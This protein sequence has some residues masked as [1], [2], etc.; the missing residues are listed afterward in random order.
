MT[1]PQIPGYTTGTWTI[2]QAHSDVSFTVRHMM[3]SRVRGCF[4]AFEGSITTAENPVEGDRVAILL[5]IEATLD[6]P[7]R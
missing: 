3:V 2:D 6:K 1:T 5:E 4:R 7:A